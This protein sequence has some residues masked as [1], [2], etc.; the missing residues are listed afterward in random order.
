MRSSPVPRP[1]P[2]DPTGGGQRE[3]RCPRAHPS[4]RRQPHLHRRPTRAEPSL[5]LPLAL[6][7]ARAGLATPR[8]WGRGPWGT[9]PLIRAIPHAEQTTGGPR[10][11]CV[12]WGRLL[13]PSDFPTAGAA[14]T[15]SL[16]SPAQPSPTGPDSINP[17]VPGTPHQPQMPQ[18]QTAQGRGRGAPFPP[19]PP[20]CLAGSRPLG[21]SPSGS[22][23]G[24]PTQQMATWELSERWAWHT[25][26]PLLPPAHFLTTWVGSSLGL[27]GAPP[28]LG[29]WDLRV[30]W[31]LATPPPPNLF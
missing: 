7:A 12:C 13:L 8:V 21:G 3:R 27:P 23:G 10:A 9:S 20:S 5:G 1:G 15:L 29:F 18:M 25:D 28:S 4:A 2:W 22:G 16:A 19:K 17:L 30:S 24:P 6:W 14:S 31:C 11:G 26:H